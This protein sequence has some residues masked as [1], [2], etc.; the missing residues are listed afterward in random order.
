MNHPFW[1]IFS[2]LI[3]FF[4]INTK[5]NYQ[6]S[7]SSNIESNILQF[8]EI[9]DLTQPDLFASNISLVHVKYMTQLYNL[10]S[11][12]ECEQG[13][14]GI[15]VRDII[16]FDS[17]VRKLSV[18]ARSLLAKTF[19]YSCLKQNIRT[20]N[21]IVNN[22][23]TSQESVIFLAEHFVPFSNEELS[24]RNAFIFEYIMF[25]KGLREN[26]IEEFPYLRFMRNVPFIKWNST[27]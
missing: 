17:V 14:P 19:Y 27:F 23:R 20:A 2:V 26:V 4:A 15:A 1:L 9:A 24:L 21:F 22:P 8:E 25:T 10:H 3:S 18:N 12:L 16:E 5:P 13:H 7:Q 11:W 6:A